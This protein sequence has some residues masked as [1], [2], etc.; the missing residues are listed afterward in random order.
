MVIQKKEQ[1]HK[2]MEAYTLK[3]KINSQ[4]AHDAPREPL[5]NRLDQIIET[6]NERK[7]KAINKYV[8]EKESE[9][10]ECTFT[11]RIISKGPTRSID[12]LFC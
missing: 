8:I 10:K 1:L 4:Q 3:P 2:E 6:R 12:D 11:P 9:M 5:L 7:Q